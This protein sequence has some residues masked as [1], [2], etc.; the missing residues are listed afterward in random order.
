MFENYG[1]TKIVQKNKLVVQNINISLKKI[2][3]EDFISLTDIARSKNSDEPKDVVKNWLRNKST[4][5]FLGLWEQV[6]ENSEFKQVEFDQFKN[7]SGSN[8]FVLS[9]LKWITTTSAKGI[10]SNSGRYGGTYAHEDIALE[11]ASWI[12]QNSNFI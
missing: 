8:S 12:L 6:N 2:S 4:V 3:N 7:K 11:F 5:E 9:P 1:R 10:I